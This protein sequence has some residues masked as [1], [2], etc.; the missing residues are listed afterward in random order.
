MD[1]TEVW[2]QDLQRISLTLVA[3]GAVVTYVNTE[4]QRYSFQAKWERQWRFVFSKVRSQCLRY[5][6]VF[7]IVVPGVCERA[8]ADMT[9]I[10]SSS[11]SGDTDVNTRGALLGAFNVEGTYLNQPTVNG[12][13][14]T[15]WNLAGAS[16]AIHGN[17]FAEFTLAPDSGI[18]STAD[19]VASLNAPFS[20]LSDSYKELLSSYAGGNNGTA[21]TL[22]INY[23]KPGNTYL[24]EWWCSESIDIQFQTTATDGQAAQNSITLSS[25]K[26][27]N[28]GDVGQ[29][30]VGTF[31]YRGTPEVI[32]FTGTPNVLNGF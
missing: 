16:S 6:A 4:T 7:L 21:V 19:N 25:R 15:H 12:V 8:L 31:I 13:T 24:L 14:F 30:A 3:I 17:L 27:D 28:D 5:V 32:T 29:F 2:Q 20:D 9:W 23:L 22:K 11:V 26:P 18:F 1:S 10:S